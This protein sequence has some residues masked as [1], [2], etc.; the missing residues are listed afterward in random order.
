MND[1][2]IVQTLFKQFITEQDICNVLQQYNYV[3][4]ARKFKV[5]DLVDFFASS[6]ILRWKSFRHGCD[7]LE[8][9]NFS[10]VSKKLNQFLLVFLKIYFS[11]RCHAV[12]GKLDV[13]YIFPN[14]CYPSILQQLHLA[15]IV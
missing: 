14:L 2:S 3:D 6:A 13:L 1:F 9:V 11:L 12:I 7:V 4:T 5:N 15:K 10:T 8:S